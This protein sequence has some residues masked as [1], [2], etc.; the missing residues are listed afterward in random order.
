MPKVHPTH[1]ISNILAFFPYFKSLIIFFI[2]NRLSSDSKTKDIKLSDTKSNMALQNR[3]MR[4]DTSSRFVR[5][6]LVLSRCNFHSTFR[7]HIY[8]IFLYWR[9]TPKAVWLSS[10]RLMTWCGSDRGILRFEIIASSFPGRF[11]PCKNPAWSS[12]F[13]RISHGKDSQI[14]HSTTS[15]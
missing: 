4:A 10:L 8:I 9:C 7:M 15:G 3:A 2:F 12:L 14:L 13:P 5:F 6:R 11:W 1:K